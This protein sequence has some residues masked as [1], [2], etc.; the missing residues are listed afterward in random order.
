[1]GLGPAR[2]TGWDDE[3]AAVMGE[4]RI[5]P[6][7]RREVGT[8]VWAMTRAMGWASGHE[9][10]KLF[11]T[12]GRHRRLLWSWLPFARRLMLAGRL[13]RRETELVI[14]RV[15]HRRR[16]AY[17]EHHHRVMARRCGLEPEEIEAVTGDLAAGPWSAR[18]AALLAGADALVD[19]GDL[20]DDQ[21]A[22]LRS[23]L[24]EVEVIELCL[25]VGHYE[26][27]ATVIQALRIEPDA[28]RP[29]ACRDA[30]R[31]ARTPRSSSDA[32]VLAS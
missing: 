25:L 17:E 1:M 21:W 7:T 2:W 19:H 15:A 31:H 27:L 14:L 13:P 10:P 28:R 11:L 16:C 5:T 30:R 3:R 23:Q 24:D 32:Q 26:M 4:P 22:A 12:L 8:A 29:H 18:E 20:D 6:G 9:P